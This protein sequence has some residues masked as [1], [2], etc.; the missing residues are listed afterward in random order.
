MPGNEACG[1]SFFCRVSIMLSPV[2]RET[3]MAVFDGQ[4]YK[5]SACFLQAY[6]W[7]GASG[8]AN[9]HITIPNQ[10]THIRSISFLAASPR[11]TE[12]LSVFTG[13]RG[14]TSDLLGH[15]GRVLFPSLDTPQLGVFSARVQLHIC[16]QE[17]RYVCLLRTVSVSSR[18]IRSRLLGRVA[19]L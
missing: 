10:E 2:A 18:R 6:L 9:S 8:G 19:E 1:K 17:H 13:R 14:S 3:S 11:C 16:R 15:V 4:Q 7:K 5:F 12:N